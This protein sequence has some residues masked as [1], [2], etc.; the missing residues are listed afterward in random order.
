MRGVN[1][2]L[3]STLGRETVNIAVTAEEIQ[4]IGRP[5]GTTPVASNGS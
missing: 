4:M 5:R 3:P 2:L 1:A